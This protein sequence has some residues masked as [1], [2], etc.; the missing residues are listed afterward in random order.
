MLNTQC[1]AKHIKPGGI[2][3]FTSG[4]DAGEVWGDNGGENLY[5][6]SLSTAEY[7]T[8]LAKHQFEVITHA[9]EDKDCGEATI[10]VARYILH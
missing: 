5:H 8:L 9:I 10:W 7:R 3:M 2:L 4:P 6:A 1:A